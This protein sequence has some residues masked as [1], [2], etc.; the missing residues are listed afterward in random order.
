MKDTFN[1][2][3]F[4]KTFQSY[5]IMLGVTWIVLV[6]AGFGLPVVLEAIPYSRL[7]IGKIVSGAIAIGFVAM[8]SLP[9]G[10]VSSGILPIGVFAF[11]A[12]ACGIIAIGGGCAI[13]VV[14]IGTNSIGVVAIGYNAMGVYVL[15][16]RDNEAKNKG[17]Y[18]FSP[19]RQD[20]KAVALFTRW[21]PK[22]KNAFATES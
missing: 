2:E 18:M 9:L 10:I 12:T 7:T 20:A 15:S 22:L 4:K 8:G 17:K 5:L 19:E 11:G 14:A 21:M 1:S 3:M 6:F 13:G 16:Y